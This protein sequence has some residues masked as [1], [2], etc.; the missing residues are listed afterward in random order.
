MIS[1]YLVVAGLL[2][3]KT[4]EVCFRAIWEGKRNGR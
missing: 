1:L 3:Y 2:G 4:L